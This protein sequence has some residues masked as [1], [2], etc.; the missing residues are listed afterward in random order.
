[1]IVIYIIYLMIVIYMI[2]LM[3]VIYIMYLMIE[4]FDNV[5]ND[6]NIYNILIDCTYI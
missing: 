4:I 1:M 3:I 6:C 5:R 2:Y